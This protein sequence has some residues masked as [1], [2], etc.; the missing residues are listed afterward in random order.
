MLERG[1]VVGQRCVHS[2]N[3]IRTTSRNGLFA[4]LFVSVRFNNHILYFR[5]Y[6][7]MKE[8]IAFK[9]NKNNAVNH[10]LV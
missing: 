2:H 3:T 10:K 9:K 8:C 6:S 4:E 5:K 7:V 1:K